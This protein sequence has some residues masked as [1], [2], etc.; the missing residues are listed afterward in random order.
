MQDVIL[1][2]GRE[3]FFQSILKENAA[4]DFLGDQV[5]QPAALLASLWRQECGVLR[6]NLSI[7]PAE[8]L[9]L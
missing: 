3:R 7:D 5:R 8:R 2:S 4:Q 9:F 1:N 6:G